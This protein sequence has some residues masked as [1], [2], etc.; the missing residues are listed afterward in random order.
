[1]SINR[2]YFTTSNETTVSVTSASTTISE[3]NSLRSFFYISNPSAGDVYIS[4]GNTA[5]I[6]KGIYLPSGS[7]YEFSSQYGNL[8]QGNIFAVT[9]GTLT[10]VV[11]VVEGSGV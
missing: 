10:R 3:A 11:S 6:G 4:L 1:M 7:A 5:E 8:F 2:Q 9:E